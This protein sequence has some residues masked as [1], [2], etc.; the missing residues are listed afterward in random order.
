MRSLYYSLLQTLTLSWVMFF[1]LV[2]HGQ[3]EPIT[4]FVGGTL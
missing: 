4:R 2:W 1:A 3:A